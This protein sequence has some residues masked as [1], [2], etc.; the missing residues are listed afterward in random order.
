[1]GKNAIQSYHFGLNTKILK[2]TLVQSAIYY[3]APSFLLLPST[4]Q[5]GKGVGLIRAEASILWSSV[6][7]IRRHLKYGARLLA[8]VFQ[9]LSRK[10]P[11]A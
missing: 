11:L 8:H 4:L 6:I 2:Q 10:G 1:M 5:R 3:F 7:A 9:G